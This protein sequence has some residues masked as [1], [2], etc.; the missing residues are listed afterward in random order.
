LSTLKD[1]SRLANVSTSTVSRYL[2][3]KL[4]VSDETR[5]RIESAVKML[6][7][8]PNLLGRSLVERKSRII[9]L[10]VPSLSNFFYAYIAEIIG[11]M[12]FEAGYKLLLCVTNRTM[13]KE[14]AYAGLLAQRLVD[15]VIYMGVHVKNMKLLNAVVRG[16]P[17]VLLDEG[18]EG[19]GGVPCVWADNY[20]GA[21]DAVRHLLGLGH[22]DIAFVG[23]NKGLESSK[24]RYRGFRDALAQSAVSVHPE[25]VI[26]GEYTEEWGAEAC[27][28]LF[29]K[30]NLK[31]FPTA[32]FAANDLIA[33]GLLERA[34]I[35]GMRVPDDVSVVGFDDIQPA[36]YC[37]P[38]LS[39]VRQPYEEMGRAAFQLLLDTL[40][41][42]NTREIVQVFPTELIMRGSTSSATVSRRFSSA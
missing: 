13:E 27:E 19:I 30:E 29:G 6:D 26:Y 22:R 35:K 5:R 23:G 37:S 4:K 41:G 38:P 31:I 33:I 21:G 39:T 24:E 15:G 16:L 10:I 9:G 28:L 18:V 34:K 32:V 42:G 2:S 25:W 7:Y 14:E 20:G 12:A 8:R 3:G 36:T 11:N 1:V 40:E 17:L